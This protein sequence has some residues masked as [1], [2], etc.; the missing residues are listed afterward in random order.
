MLQRSL[1]KGILS[2]L[3]LLADNGHF[4]IKIYTVFQRIS[5]E[6]I[7]L[8]YSL[9]EDL[10]VVK[11]SATSQRKLVRTNMFVKIFLKERFAVCTNFRQT[12][13]KGIREKMAAMLPKI[14]SEDFLNY[15]FS[16]VNLKLIMASRD[17]IKFV[18]GMNNIFIQKL[19]EKL[20]SP[21]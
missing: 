21:K 12:V 16:F 14:C 19:L 2:A 1:F 18:D 10:R 20:S 5:V 15:D 9:F 17:F 6:L 13:G 7:F 11:L 3:Y 4:I 8:L